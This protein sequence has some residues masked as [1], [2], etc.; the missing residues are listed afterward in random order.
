MIANLIRGHKK[1]VVLAGVIVLL[2]IASAVV[3]VTNV[4]RQQDRASLVQLKDEQLDTLRDASST[5]QPAVNA[6]LA[7]YVEAYVAAGSRDEAEQGSKK[8]RDAFTK[9]EA[10]ARDAME[11]VKAS[12]GAGDAEVGDAIAQ[13]EDSYLGFVDYL[14]GLVDSY[15]Q[16]HSL[17]GEGDENCQGIF[18]GSRATTL[19]ERKDLLAEAADICR[20]ATEKL[21]NSTNPTYVEYARRVD[22][23]VR[24]LELD[25]T[26]TAKAEK[27]L[28]E[29]TAT[30]DQL[31]QKADEAEARNASEE[32]LFDLADEVESLSSEI[33]ASEAEFDFAADRYT[34]TVK[35]MPTLL[36]EVFSTHVA[37]ELE[38]F[39]SVI[40]LRLTV[41]KAVI[42]DRLVE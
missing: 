1:L 31:V 25:S 27:S 15:P 12:R 29:F 4:A 24:Q 8:E 37:G 20:S 41:L 28:E 22:N 13:Y 40:P 7:A 19:N 30:K 34:T 11:T 39:D 6:Y 3:I 16:F 5:L 42:E 36:E 33:A 21:G 38:H 35:E 23:R 17:F 26:V 9:A 10:S 2:L 32:E 18:V 14:A